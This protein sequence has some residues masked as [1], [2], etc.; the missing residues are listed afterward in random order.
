MNSRFLGRTTRPAQ[1][2]CVIASRGPV[3]P[4][5]ARTAR[6]GSRW[7]PSPPRRGVRVDEQH[8]HGARRGSASAA[9][10]QGEAP[11][12]SQG[13]A[14]RGVREMRGRPR[15][16]EHFRAR[17]GAA[18]VSRPAS[19]PTPSTCASEQDPSGVRNSPGARNLHLLR[20]R[21]RRAVSTRVRRLLRRDAR[22]R[23]LCA[24]DRIP[25]RGLTSSPIVLQTKTCGAR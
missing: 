17:G 24:R 12:S 5:D 1:G 20:L 6:H 18:C 10:S 22:G 7:R 19:A 16:V 3:R 21:F 13:E 11:P 2:F 25:S 23:Q 9:S 15:R 8:S 4:N 14:P